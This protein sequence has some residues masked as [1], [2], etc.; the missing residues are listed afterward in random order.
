[1]DRNRNIATWA[2]TRGSVS[3]TYADKVT[4]ARSYLRADPTLVPDLIAHVRSGFRI[5][6]APWR[7][8]AHDSTVL[9]AVQDVAPSGFGPLTSPGR[10]VNTGLVA[11]GLVG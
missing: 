7:T 10:L 5:K 4:D 6:Y 2:V 8:A 3:S 1:V 11:G 9:G